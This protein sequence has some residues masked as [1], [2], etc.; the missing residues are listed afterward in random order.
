MASSQTW[1]H[2]NVCYACAAQIELQRENEEA[3]A[4]AA[5]ERWYAM[6]EREEAEIAS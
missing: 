2:T 1:R 3:S 4:S 5:Q 6:R